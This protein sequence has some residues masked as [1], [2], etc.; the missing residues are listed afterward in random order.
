MTIELRKRGHNAFS[1]DLETC[2]GGHF[3][4]HIQADVLP[5]INGNCEFMTMDSAVHQIVGKWDMIIAFPPCTYLTNA[6]TRH[7]SPKCNTPDKIA[8]REKLRKAAADFFIRLANADCERIAI[9]NPVGFM[10]RHYEPP[11]QIIEPYF[12][13]ESEDD[14]ENYFTKRTCLWLKGLPKLE[15]TNNLPR[16]KPLRTYTN[17]HGKKKSVCWC[18]DVS[19]ANQAKRAKLRSKTFPGIAREMA[20]QWG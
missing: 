5:L 6:G 19:G 13:A 7:F 18:M 3:E 14:K 10:N 2:S 4:W 16:P 17:I 9:E 11:T 12:F 20:R 1:C 8:A 15:R